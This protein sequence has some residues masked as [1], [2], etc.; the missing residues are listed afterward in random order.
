MLI[1]E[2]VY[3]VHTLYVHFSFVASLLCVCMQELPVLGHP[4]FNHVFHVTLALNICEI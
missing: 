2:V 1:C 3:I 4:F